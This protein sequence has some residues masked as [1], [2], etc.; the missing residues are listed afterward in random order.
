[1]TIEK[2]LQCDAATLESFTNE[3]LLEWFKPMLV[4]TRPELAV[5]PE[6]QSSKQRVQYENNSKKDKAFELLKS[7]GINVKRW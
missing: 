3:Q 1:M 6:K 7:M 5:K 2:L 4:V